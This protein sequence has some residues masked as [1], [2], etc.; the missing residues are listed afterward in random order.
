MR[1]FTITL[2]ETSQGDVVT[3]LDPTLYGFVAFIV[4]S[5]VL[6]GRPLTPALRPDL[7]SLQETARRAYWYATQYPNATEAE[8]V[9]YRDSIVWEDMERNQYA[10]VTRWLVSPELIA[11]L[12]FDD[13]PVLG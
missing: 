9:A 11:P 12:A 1:Q 7:Y 3:T 4:G 5:R 10:G 6:L 2:N 13:P 8:V